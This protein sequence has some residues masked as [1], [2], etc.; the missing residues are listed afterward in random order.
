MLRCINLVAI[1]S[2][3]AYLL[4]DPQG[5]LSCVV[6]PR[7]VVRGTHG[8]PWTRLVPHGPPWYKLICWLIP[9][10]RYPAWAAILR[11]PLSCMGRYPAWATILHGPILRGPESV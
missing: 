10:G 11:G 1:H 2:K 7:I 4:A 8:P 9:V 6:P 5:P 3:R